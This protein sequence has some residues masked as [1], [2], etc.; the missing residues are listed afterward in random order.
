MNEEIKHNEVA[1]EEIEPKII[2]KNPETTPESN[3]ATPEKSH[4]HILQ[5]ESVD[6]LIQKVAKEAQSNKDV[7]INEGETINKHTPSPRELKENAFNNTMSTVRDKLGWWPGKLSTFIHKPA[8]EK[9]SDS[10]GKTVS[11][12]SGLLGGGMLAL[13][14]GGIGLYMASKYG[15]EYNSFIFFILFVT[16]YFAGLLIEFIISIFHRRS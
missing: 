4:E 1:Q 8:V 16:G 9:F 12:P 11:R 5:P 14:G 3:K 6:A 10:A 15:F 2:E 13:I 7:N